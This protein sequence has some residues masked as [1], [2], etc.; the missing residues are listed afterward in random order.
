ML[1]S[2]FLKVIKLEILNVIEQASGLPV[3]ALSSD[4]KEEQIIYNLVPVS[5]DGILKLDRLELNIICSTLEKAEAADDSIRTALLSAGDL[6]KNGVQDI[7]VNG[8]GT[9]TSEIGVHRFVNYQILWRK[10]NGK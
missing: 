4:K 6:K 7:A 3:R 9:L 1:L 8:G 2:N 5:D 10:R